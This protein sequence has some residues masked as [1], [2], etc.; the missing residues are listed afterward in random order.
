MCRWRFSAPSTRSSAR[1]A[2]PRRRCWSTWSPPGIW[3]ARPGEAFA[4]MERNDDAV[5]TMERNDDAVATM[6]RNDDA[7]ATMERNSAAAGPLRVGPV[8]DVAGREPVRRDHGSGAAG[9]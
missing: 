2:T 1:A 4:T 8:G 3:G 9:G 7:V 6:E 5:A